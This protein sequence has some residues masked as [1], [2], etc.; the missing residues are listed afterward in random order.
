MLALHTAQAHALL[1]IAAVLLVIMN[2]GMQD[3]WFCAA[4]L[5]QNRR[6]GAREGEGIVVV[7]VGCVAALRVL[8]AAY[9]VPHASLMRPSC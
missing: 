4:T 8:V 1:C 9:T 5:V 6:G 3:A 2:G 7:P